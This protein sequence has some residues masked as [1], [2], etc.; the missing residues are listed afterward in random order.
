[1]YRKSVGRE[2]K[3]GG[4]AKKVGALGGLQ[5]RERTRTDTWSRKK[6]E[7]TAVQRTKRHG[8]GE[9]KEQ[10]CGP[11]SVGWRGFYTYSCHAFEIAGSERVP[12]YQVVAF[13][14][15]EKDV[16]RARNALAHTCKHTETKLMAVRS[17]LRELLEI[18]LGNEADGDS[19]TSG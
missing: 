9:R 7:G 11:P 10:L 3:L 19:S 8:L 15:L 1:M 4:T 2:T 5:E 16:Q 18:P 17:R 13:L 12:E 6:A 14:C